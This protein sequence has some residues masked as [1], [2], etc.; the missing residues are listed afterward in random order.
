MPTSWRIV[1]AKHASQAF[2]GEGA[3]EYGGRWNSPGIPMIYTSATMSLAALEMLVHLGRSRS[4]PE[5]VV[6]SCRFSESLIESLDRTA[7]PGH[8]RAYPAPSELAALGDSW[9]KRGRSPVLRVPSAVIDSESNF[10]LNPQHPDFPKIKI[11]SSEPF[12]LD[13]RLLR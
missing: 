11:S 7:L 3:R 12:Q 10:L 9:I 8:W 1:K 6:F 13:L 4:L 2:D 5:Y